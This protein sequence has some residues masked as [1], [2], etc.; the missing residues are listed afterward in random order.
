MS[1]IELLRWPTIAGLLGWSLSASGQDAP[2]AVPLAG[3]D[4]TSALLVQVLESG[5]LPV[6]LAFVVWQLT[7]ASSGFTPTLRVIH[8][9]EDLPWDG[10]ERRRSSDSER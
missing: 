2:V 1:K 7:R 10:R 5:S 8:T 6:V 3:L 4:P 9:R